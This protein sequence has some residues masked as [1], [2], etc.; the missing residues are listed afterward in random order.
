MRVFLSILL[1]ALL[2]LANAL[3]T[4]GNRLLV[5]L[6]ELAEK[7]KYGEFMGDLKGELYSTAVWR[8]IV[9]GPFVIT[10]PDSYHRKRL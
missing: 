3:S 8:L 10:S 4:A 6:E 1:L 9:N 7:E 5:L 2:G